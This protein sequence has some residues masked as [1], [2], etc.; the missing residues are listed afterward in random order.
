MG[1]LDKMLGKITEKALGRPE[2]GA[3]AFDA[4]KT[5]ERAESMS[6]ALSEAIERAY[7][8]RAD[9]EAE[10]RETEEAL[11][12]PFVE[13]S[14]EKLSRGVTKSAAMRLEGRDN[15]VVYKPRAAETQLRKGVPVGTMALRDWLSYQIDRAAALDTVPAT[16][17]RDGPQ[18]FGSV[19]DWKAGD[20]PIASF[21]L[22]IAWEQ[23][24]EAGSVQRLAAL[25]RLSCN[26]DRNPGNVLLDAESK[27]HGIDNSLIFS[28][29]LFERVMSAGMGLPALK[30]RGK[31]LLPDVRADLQR[32]RNAPDVLAA[33]RPC[34]DLALGQD[35]DWAW[36]KFN[37]EL[38]QLSKKGKF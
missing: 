22:M 32:L 13:G 37:E 16:V 31:E 17:L 7:P 30:M 18:G 23:K 21:E 35:A 29:S 20:V 19:R 25:D 14:G 11:M 33:L 2:S 24:A 36:E 12:A 9:A 6:D 27:A 1:L 10:R 28:R 15:P 4:A 38:E 8:D 26:T 34:F 5:I 3:E